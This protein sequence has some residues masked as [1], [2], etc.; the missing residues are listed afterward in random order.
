MDWKHIAEWHLRA[1]N[2]LPHVVPHVMVRF[3]S[4]LLPFLFSANWGFAFGYCLSDCGIG[5]SFLFF[6]F[7]VSFGLSVSHRVPAEEGVTTFASWTIVEGHVTKAVSFFCFFF[8]NIPFLTH[9]RVP[10]EGIDLCDCCGRAE[11]ERNSKYRIARS[12]WRSLRICA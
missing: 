4:P 3:C 5:P 2:D 11:E 12:V 8:E 9:I 6:C 7:L 10:G 1:F